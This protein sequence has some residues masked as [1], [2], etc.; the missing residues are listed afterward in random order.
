LQV[1]HGW[2]GEIA[3]RLDP[4]EAVETER[5]LS[6]AEVRERVEAYLEQIAMQLANGEVPEWLHQPVEHLRTVLLRLERVMNLE[7]VKVPL[8]AT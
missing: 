6:G 8:A 3:K 2:L 4:D 5:R 1:A 7:Q